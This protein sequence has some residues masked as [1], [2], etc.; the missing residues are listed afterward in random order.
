MCGIFGV[1]S[2]DVVSK[3]KLKKINDSNEVKIIASYENGDGTKDQ[4]ESIINFSPIT[5]ACANPSG[6]GCTAYS[7]FIPH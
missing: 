4:D 1:I 7:I 2:Q 3:E 6:L 5:K